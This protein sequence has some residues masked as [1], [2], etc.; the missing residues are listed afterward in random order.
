M[1]NPTKQTNPANPKVSLLCL[2]PFCNSKLIKKEGK[3]KTK[4]GEIQKYC[5]LECNKYFSE[6]NKY[7]KLK[8]KSYP[9]RIILN[10]ISL[11]NLGHSLSQTQK[12]MAARFKIK[13]P[14]TTISSWTNQ[15]SKICTF[16]RLRHEAKKLF[17]PAEIILSEKLQHRQVYNFQLHKA[18]LQ[19]LENA[20]KETAEIPC[21][22]FLLLKNYL[23]KIPT[24]K[25]PHHIFTISSEM[26]EE[27][28]ASQLNMNHL[29]ITKLQKQNYACRLAELALKIS[30]NNKARHE[31]IQN[32]MLV[33][34]SVTI[35]AE[36]PVYLTNDDIKYF[37]Q[38]G[39]TFDFENYRTP[40]TGHI[41]LLQIRNG[42]IHILD[43]KPEASKVNAVEQLTIYA[44]A[45]A[46]RTKLAV[47]DFKCAWFDENNYF[48]FFPL[49]A[50]YEKK[51]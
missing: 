10:A 28:R 20:N 40:I 15:Y 36:V 13:L 14:I 22:K 16:S 19:L 12:I 30:P 24:E 6:Q 8:Y 48:E 45:L 42:L 4:I 37:M 41:D 43:Y 18:K 5:C 33:N 3:R 34:D 2:C 38:K 27:K 32:F 7:N 44:L 46:S 49:H 23:N 11:Y 39:F 50:V 25:F 9:A 31:T 26:Q 51:A 1:P 21:Q 17:L 47:K 29:E 35:A